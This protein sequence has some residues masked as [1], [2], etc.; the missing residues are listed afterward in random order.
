MRTGKLVIF[1]VAAV[2][3]GIIIDHGVQQPLLV[4][5][6]LRAV[7]EELVRGG[8]GLRALEW[9]ADGSAWP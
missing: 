8:R 4:V 2:M 1:V 6:G 5:S 7:V 3:S 9:L